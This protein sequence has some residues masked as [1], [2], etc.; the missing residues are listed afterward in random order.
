MRSG[1]GPGDRGRGRAIGEG[2]GAARPDRPPQGK[3]DRAKRLTEVTQDRLLPVAL[4]ATGRRRLSL[5]VGGAELAVEDVE[6]F[7]GGR[8]VQRRL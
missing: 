7:V 1:Q 2:A 4:R 8:S 3:S 5:S 6:Q